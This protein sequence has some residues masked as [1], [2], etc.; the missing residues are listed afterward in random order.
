MKIGLFTDT[1]YPQISGVAASISVLKDQLVA[2]GHDVYIFTTTDPNAPKYEERIYRLQ[3]LPFVSKRR[4]GLCVLPRL[5]KLVIRLKIDIIH[6]H[7][8]FPLGQ[9]GRWVSRVL[10]LPLVHTMHTIYEDYTHYVVPG[11]LGTV[12]AKKVAIKMT[13]NFCNSADEVIV[14]TIKTQ[15]LLLSYGVDKRISIIPTGIDL[16]KFSPSKHDFE[17][18]QNLKE[19]LGISNKEKVMLYIGRVSEEKNIKEVLQY[20][21]VYMRENNG[22]KFLVIGD[23]PERIALEE[24]AKILG[25]SDNV[26]FAGQRKWTEIARYYQL[27]DVFV[28]ASQSETQGLTYIEALSAGI[29][30]I[31]KSDPC[32][33]GVVQNGINGYTFEGQD[34]FLEALNLILS[35]DSTRQRMANIAEQSVS[36]YSS[37]QYGHDV[38]KLYIETSQTKYDRATVVR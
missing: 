29:P 19:S 31:A 10:N 38:E 17:D 9:Y 15:Q 27:G 28:T 21:K 32:I 5:K 13:K 7:T 2:R 35:D 26:I 11:K 3:S 12:V 34:D 36:R 22:V 6:T 20:T 30:V 37:R 18:I 14:P 16:E 1:Y 23:G 8:E 4:I 25:I 33:E 24:E